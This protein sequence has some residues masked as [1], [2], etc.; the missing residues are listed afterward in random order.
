MATLINR[1]PYTVRVPR[2]TELTREFPHDKVQAARA[3]L[4]ELRT[5]GHPAVN[6]AQCQSCLLQRFITIEAHQG[7]GS[8]EASFPS[9][10]QGCEYQP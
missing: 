10:A 6:A 3:Y 9:F 1:S 4:K 2:C 7:T 5:Q 8:T